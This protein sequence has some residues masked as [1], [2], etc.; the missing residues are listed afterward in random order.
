MAWIYLITAGGLEIIATTLFRYTD[1][2]TRIGPTAGFLIVGLA[3]FYCLQKS[4]V[5]IPLGTAYAIWTGIGA[6]GTALI[7]L[8]FYDEPST[9]MRLLFLTILIASIIGLKFVS[10]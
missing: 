1:S 7:G 2:L 6:A 3:S 8:A 4:I 10:D 9:A 5:E